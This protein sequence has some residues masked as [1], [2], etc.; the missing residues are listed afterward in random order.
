MPSFWPPRLARPAL[1]LVAAVSLGMSLGALALSAQAQRHAG[2]VGVGAQVGRPGGVSL[3][4][5]RSPRAAIDAALTTDGDDRAVLHLYG[6][7]EWALST[8]AVHAM[9]GP[10][11]AVGTTR[12]AEQGRVA[13]AAAGGLAGL[14]FFAERF[15]VF[16][17]VTPRVR[18][19]PKVDGVL[20][21]SVGLR[22]FF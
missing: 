1:V 18:F 19:L 16:L 9:A 3:K 12:T 15:E 7:R 5:Y 22:Y 11:L 14:N 20:G 21:G 13:V 10:G 4:A 17:H 2:A 8:T 6:V